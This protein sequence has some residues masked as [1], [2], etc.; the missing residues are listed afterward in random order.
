M[1]KHVTILDGS[2]TPLPDATRKS[3]QMQARQNLM[4]SSAAYRGG[5]YSHPATSNWHSSRL[6]GHAALSM[7][8]EKLNERIRDMTR[9]DS[10]VASGIDRKINNVVGDGFRL[11]VQLDGRLLN[12]TSDEI[13]TI[14]GQIEALWK[15]Y[16]TETGL[17]ADAERQGTVADLVLLASRDLETAG[18]AFG[19]LVWRDNPSPCGFQTAMQCI[20]PARCSNPS[21]RQDNA[22]LRDGV[23]LDDFSAPIGYWFR[24]SHP[25]EIASLGND[26]YVWDYF[27]RNHECGRPRICHVKERM[28][29][30]MYRGVSKLVSVM[31]KQRQGE[32]YM[33]YE[34]QAAML[35]AVMALFIETP[36]DQFELMDAVTP[37]SVTSQ[38]QV[39]QAIHKENPLEMQGAQVNILAPGERPHQLKADHPNTA[40]EPFMKNI[41][42]ACASVLGITYEQLTGDWSDV[43]YSSAR[44]AI[45]EAAK[46]FRVVANRLK[47]H[48]LGP[49]YRAW[50]EE[51]FD[52]GYI[53]IPDHAPSFDDAPDAWSAADWIGAGKGYVDPMKEVQA[54]GLRIALGLSTWEKE[55]AEQGEDYREM[56]AQVV[57]EI[58]STRQE[59]VKAG[60]PPDLIQH[61]AMK[62]VPS[63]S[64]LAKSFPSDDEET[65]KKKSRS[66]VPYV[67]RSTGELANA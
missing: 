9:N 18:E 29:A 2:G 22:Y 11:S 6:S 26:R 60:L 33:D 23:Q 32:N 50:L 35:N 30:G 36:F 38:H 37:E 64:L 56:I 61:P 16:A 44:A 63:S 51:A 54:A 31:T 57:R 7:D 65:P 67:R 13:E 14:S 55:C 66:G 10:H 47:T 4:M 40:F 48:F 27:E 41:L 58:K 25:G 59:L 20:H 62:G 15:V 42:R 17:H 19:N 45:L 5:N 1:T 21:N 52:K 12:L 43:N 49:W 39:N 34:T 46:G 28:E 24:R 3:A 8:R 53:D